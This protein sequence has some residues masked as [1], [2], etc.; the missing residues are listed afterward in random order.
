MTD[1]DVCLTRVLFSDDRQECLSYLFGEPMNHKSATRIGPRAGER[2][3]ARV[4]FFVVAVVLILV[5]YSGYVFLPVAYDSYL[6]KDLMQHD[7]DVASTMGYKTDWVRDQLTKAG[8]EYNVPADAVITVTQAEN[9][10]VCNV[11]FIRQIPFPGYTYSYQFDYTAKSTAFLA[12][13]K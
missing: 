9:R 3:G 7:V 10:V 11:Q 12:M 4:K 13:P 5:A 8:P 1:T 6:Y 2:G